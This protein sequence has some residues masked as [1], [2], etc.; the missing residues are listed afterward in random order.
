MTKSFT[1]VIVTEMPTQCLKLLVGVMAPGFAADPPYINSGAGS[2]AVT[3]RQLLDGSTHKRS[4]LEYIIVIII[5]CNNFLPLIMKSDY[6]RNT[7]TIHPS[8][9]YS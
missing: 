8:T 3:Q 9:Q 2:P 7:H 6:T 1:R 5:T 4:Y